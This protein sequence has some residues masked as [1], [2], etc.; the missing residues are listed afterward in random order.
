M[1]NTIVLILLLSSTASF[2]QMDTVWTRHYN[3][4]GNDV[5]I[6]CAV[7]VDDSGNV[8]VTG[9]SIGINTLEDYATI[10]YD[11]SG[12]SIWVSR[13][14]GVWGGTDY[15]IG[16]IV[17]SSNNVY[18]SGSSMGM[19]ATYDYATIKYSS[20]G[21]TLWV[22]LLSG[23]WGDIDYVSAFDVN[24]EGNVFVTGT[25]RY[26]WTYLNYMT[27]KYN[28]IGDTLWVR[29]YNH[30]AD[31]DDSATAIATDGDGNVYVTGQSWGYV[32]GYD[33][34]T[35]KYDAVGNEVWVSRY[36]GIS[37]STD[38][39]KAIVVDNVGNIYVTGESWTTGSGYDIVTV[40]YNGNGD[41][42]WTRRYNGSGNS[43]D[44]ASALLL[45][46]ENNVCVIGYAREVNIDYCTIKYDSAGNELW[47]A[48]YNGVGNGADMAYAAVLDDSGNVYVTGASFGSGTLGDYAT[49]KYDINGNEMWVAR[50]N[51][52]MT[53]SF[54][55]AYAI[56]VD[57]AGY[58]YVTGESGIGAGVDYVKVKYSQ[59]TGI[60]EDIVA[61]KW[62]AMVV[63]KSVFLDEVVIDYT[64]QDPERISLQI[65]DIQGRLVKTLVNNGLQCGNNRVHWSGTDDYDRESPAGVY[66]ARLS[67]SH[68]SL[69]KKIVKLK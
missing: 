65:Y 62:L 14:D 2:A 5:D 28:N 66:L 42:I 56:A 41:T 45:D 21:D 53:N 35:V 20:S 36:N 27:V 39:A 33:Y 32:T 58:V 3:G 1:K 13:Y 10:R 7:A 15:P 26:A 43:Y 55:K 57:T 9:S 50:Y 31:K 59:V 11:V 4:P 47:V 54:D 48:H 63:R 68:N 64:L 44:Y 6:A 22:R 49:V 67:N 38:I 25:T 46:D 34:T 37:D 30:T 60:E 8:Y 16:L 61:R 12:D 19:D 51:G 23:L 52:I 29:V 24:E 69:T 40:K 18:V 17:D